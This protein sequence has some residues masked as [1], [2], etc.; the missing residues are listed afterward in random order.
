MKRYTLIFLIL[1]SSTTGFA[2]IDF[3]RVKLGLQ[4]SPTLS[5]NRVNDESADINFSGD[6]VG[7]RMIGGVVVDYM[8]T[9]NYFVSTGLF[10][11]PKRVGIRDNR[12]PDEIRDRYKL[13]YLQ[14]P[15]TMK[16]FTNEVALDTRIYFQA[17]FTLDIKLLEDNI[18]EQTTYVEDFGFID[19]SLLLAAGAEYRYGYNTI[20]FGGF[21][22]RRGL[23]NVVRN[24]A[25]PAQDIVVKNDLFSL[26]LGIKF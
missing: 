1:A 22:Y 20:F 8:L 18:S 7:G 10:F 26:D 19:S 17:G 9:D 15:A 11:V 5:F 6:G 12:R 2:Q 24:E 16:L 23:A 4:V 25:A 3:S 21:S 14:I 13:H